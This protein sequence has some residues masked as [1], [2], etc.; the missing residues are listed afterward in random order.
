MSDTRE[1]RIFLEPDLRASAV[2]G[3]HNFINIMT[4]VLQCAGFSVIFEDADEAKGFGAAAWPGYTLFH[5]QAPFANRSLTFRRVYYYPFWAIEQ[6][7]KRWSWEVAKATFPSQS[8]DRKEANRFYG[9]WQK[10]LFGQTPKTAHRDGFVYVPL[11]GRLLYHRSF[12]FCSPIR[13][14]E[15]VLENDPNRDIVATL[16]P[17]ETYSAR[18]LAALDT[19]QSRFPRLSV[20]IGEMER[21][22]TGCDYVVTENSSAAF[23]GYFFEKPAVLFAGI[24]FHHIAAKVSELGPGDAICAVMDQSPDY[25]G[26]IHWFWQQM[27]INA[28]RPDAEARVA[29]KFKNAGWPV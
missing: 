1:I 28:G 18:D 6:T 15:H 17:N 21:W 8:V 16:H 25:A 26:Y 14:I 7:D 19:L 20:K 10:R 5:M 11:Q 9:F 27:S 4:G 3:R 22:L 12:Q 23:S 29:Q 2:A 13:M 24:D